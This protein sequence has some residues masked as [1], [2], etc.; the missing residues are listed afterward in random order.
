MSDWFASWFGEEYLA[1][2]AHRDDADAERLFALVRRAVPWQPG[3]RVLD[4]ACGPGR[5]TRLFRAAGARAVGLDLSAVLLRRARELTDAPLVR[6]DMRHLP[7]RAGSID[8]AVNLFTSFGYFEDDATHAGVIRD[9][10]TALRPGGWFVLDFL[11]AERVRT[12]VA[13]AGAASTASGPVVAQKTLSPDGRFVR[14]TITGDDGRTWEER[15]RLLGEAE[16]EAM[17]RAA[18]L[19]VVARFGDYDGGPVAPWAP[20]VIVVG[21][22]A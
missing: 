11:N 2:Y 14:K 9:I 18:G 13:A 19:A 4:V 16:L 10:A 12:E 21:Q 22:R 17:F 1:L 15:V 6:A 5:H 7:V 8:L 3:W 20:R